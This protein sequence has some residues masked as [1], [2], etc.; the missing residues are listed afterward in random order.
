MM[1]FT[2]ANSGQPFSLP[3]NSIQEAYEGEGICRLIDINGTE[4]DVSDT[5]A[6]VLSQL[7]GGGG[8]GG[9]GGTIPSAGP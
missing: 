4:Y 1:T 9:G 2:D 3:N 7:T 5:W 6:Q 8:G